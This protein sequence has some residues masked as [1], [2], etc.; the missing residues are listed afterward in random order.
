MGV[1]RTYFNI[2]GAV[3]LNLCDWWLGF[4]FK[5]QKTPSRKL[6]IWICV[7]PC[8]PFH[9]TIRLFARDEIDNG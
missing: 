6:D 5:P 2:T 8:I 1:K 4:Y 3:E 7:L 9:V